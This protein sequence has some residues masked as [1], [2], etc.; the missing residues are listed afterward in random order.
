MTSGWSDAL[1]YN[2]Q[3]GILTGYLKEINDHMV[4]GETKQVDDERKE[5]APLKSLATDTLYIPDYDPISLSSI[6]TPPSVRYMEMAHRPE[7]ASIILA[8]FLPARFR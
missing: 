6:G 8:R 1:L 7:K 5:K 4:S 2:W 3:P